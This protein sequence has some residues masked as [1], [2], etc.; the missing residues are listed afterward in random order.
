M[1]VGVFGGFLLV[2]GMVCFRLSRIILV[3]V[4][5]VEWVERVRVEVGRLVRRLLGIFR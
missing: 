1:R 2:E 5:K 3:V 4:L